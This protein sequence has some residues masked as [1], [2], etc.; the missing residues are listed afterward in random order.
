MLRIQKRS[1]K[2]VVYDGYCKLAILNITPVAN[3]GRN[4]LGAIFR[5]QLLMIQ[6]GSGKEL[7][8]LELRDGRSLFH[9]ELVGHDHSFL[10][11]S[12]ETILR[13]IIKCLE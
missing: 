11:I 6:Q 3:T 9:L 12:W 1:G 10:S 13:V 8:Y 5:W 7:V 4:A 2:E